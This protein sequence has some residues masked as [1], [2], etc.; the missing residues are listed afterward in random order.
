MGLEFDKKRLCLL[1]QADL[2]RL[3][4]RV[5]KEALNPPE[6]PPPFAGAG[7]FWRQSFP[8]S[9]REEA[10]ALGKVVD[11]YVGGELLKEAVMPPGSRVLVYENSVRWSWAIDK[12][13]IP[14]FKFLPLAGGGIPP[15]ILEALEGR[16]V[17]GVLQIKLP[18]ICFW[19]ER[20]WA[21]EAGTPITIAKGNYVVVGLEQKGGPLYCS[22]EVRPADILF[23]HIVEARYLPAVTSAL[24]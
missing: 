19:P 23:L 12:V 21:S 15:E 1:S 10:S 7:E 6:V 18:K 3:A 16:K 9:T 11:D 13:G 24:E 5:E 20:P 2:A 14:G 17:D 8:V 22:E 4:E